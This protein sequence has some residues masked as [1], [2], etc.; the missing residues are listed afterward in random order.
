MQPSI[1]VA[2]LSSLGD[3]AKGDQKRV[4]ETL[5]KLSADRPGNGIRWHSVEGTDFISLSSS[6]ELRVIGEQANDHVVLHHVDHHDAAYDWARRHRAVGGQTLEVVGI[7]PTEVEPSSEEKP[8]A[9]GDLLST[10]LLES[11]L[12]R[13]IAEVLH[14]CSDEDD[15]LHRLT[16]MSPPWQEVILRV[17]TGEQ[18]STAEIPLPSDTVRPLRDDLDLSAALELPIRAW[19]LFLHPR[20]RSA[21]ENLVNRVT[22][23]VGGPGTGK[24]LVCVHR[25][26][27]LANELPRD[28][29]ILVYTL[30]RDLIA[31]LRGQIAAVYPEEPGSRR[32]WTLSCD[33]DP[34]TGSHEAVFVRDGKTLLRSGGTEREVGAI[35]IDEFQDCPDSF[36]TF[37]G[38]VIKD[39]DCRFV[40]L[41]LDPHQRLFSSIH[42]EAAK[43]VL[44]KAKVMPLSYSYRMTKP[45][46]ENALNIL[47]TYALDFDNLLD[48]G[49]GIP[50]PISAVAGPRVRYVQV[51]G[52]NAIVDQTRNS[53]L[54]LNTRYSQEAVAVIHAQ[55]SS[56]HFR[57]TARVEPVAEALKNDQLIGRH[58]QFG[59]WVKGKEFFAGV[60][61]CP[62]NFLARSDLPKQDV[63]LRLNTLFVALTRFR[64]ELTVIYERGAPA[65]RFFPLDA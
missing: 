59:F 10:R 13:R 25:A 4:R 51:E 17:A 61:V 30:G 55:Y 65:A 20:Q 62:S 26:A 57:R 53:L 54:D 33:T 49:V 9:Y 6:D 29:V 36:T 35:L 38:R 44:S 15:L 11:H 12:P 7:V 52:L 63:L 42:E 40:T 28:R 27:F 34:R 39:T 31:Q 21:V 18:I 19:G 14:A 60:V 5:D 8:S 56:P 2:F 37:L 43:T 47:G 45:L 58:Y 23:V 24:S 16:S 3:L 64:S 50:H 22:C 32:I 48:V 1:S 41:S 46:M